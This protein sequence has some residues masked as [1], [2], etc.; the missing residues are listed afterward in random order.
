MKLRLEVVT[1]RCA[2][3]LA[4]ERREPACW[5]R[6]SCSGRRRPG[7]VVSFELLL[8]KTAPDRCTASRVWCLLLTSRIHADVRNTGGGLWQPEAAPTAAMRNS[9]DHHAERLKNILMD[10][11][12]RKSFLSDAPKQE[13]KAVKAFVVSNA[14]NALK[15]KPKVCID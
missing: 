13:S 10:V 15:T 8:P 3:L 9:I 7:D 12:V 4:L 11:G 6:F 5:G 14:G 1:D 2:T